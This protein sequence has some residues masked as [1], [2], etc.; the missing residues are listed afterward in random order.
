MSKLNVMLL[1]EISKAKGQFIAA[2]AVILA[3]IVMFSATYLS[4]RNL[5]NSLD[6]YYEQY[7]FLDYYAEARYIPE[8]IV[9]KVEHIKGVL[10]VSGRVSA[11][12]GA[13][14]GEERRI[15]LRILSLPDNGRPAVN[16]I[17]SI[18]GDYFN[19]RA[20]N[21]C[22]IN[23]KFAEY[24]NLHKGGTI[25]AIIDKRIYEFK[26]DGVVGSPE[27]IYAMKSSDSM[28]SAAENFGVI[29]VK[30]ST[31]F[32]LLG[33]N[34]CFN[35]LHVRFSAEADRKAIINQIEKMLVPYGFMSGVE[36]KDQLSNAMIETELSELQNMAVMFP[37]LFLSVAA[38]IIYNMLRRI[39]NNQRTQIGV[40]KSFGYTNQRIIFHYMGYAALIGLTGALA[41]S[42][43]GWY[44]GS[45]LTAMYTKVYNIPV[46]ENK[47]YW[48]VFLIGP[49]ISAIFCLTSG[50]NSA[51][52]VLGIEP[53][54]AM[55]PETPGV[56]RR[57]FLERVNFLWNKLS[58]GW[59]MSFRNIFR[60]R[61][62]AFLTLLGMIFTVMFLIISLYFFDA[63]N[64][65][66][67]QHFFEFQRQDYKVSF[68]APAS[69]ADAL[70]L[71]RIKGVRRSE[72]VLEIP[73]QLINGW[74]KEETLVVGLTR[75]NTFY[76][77]TDGDQNAIGV[78]AKGILIA[79]SLAEKLRV[80]KG[81]AISIKTYQGRTLQKDIIVAGTIKQYAGTNC[82][83]DL[84]ELGGLLE[85][86][87]FANG[88]L[89]G[90]EDGMERTVR[91][92]I[93][94]I[95]GV[96]TLESRLNSYRAFLQFME[97]IYTFIALML[98]F[99]SVMG[100]AIV[101]NTTVI[102][103][104][105]R[106]RELASLKVLGYTSGE[107]ERTV[108]RENLCLGLLSLLPGFIL[109]RSMCE[110]LSKMFGGELISLEVFIYPKT[111]LIATFSALTFI[112]L[113]QLANR[114]NITGLDMVEVLKNRE[115]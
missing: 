56:G 12:V 95:P 88:A 69:L 40:L 30:E 11:D 13:D 92:E 67:E 108:F 35:E 33:Y 24:H 28:F 68:S 77:L 93:F 109:G 57:I 105:E 16:H 61:Q 62:R 91:K 115:G 3:G 58:F 4:Y 44:T 103:I 65:L 85:E 96:E 15:T 98:I 37:I 55:R 63:V 106:R 90:I 86:G 14:I 20:E 23:R 87:G 49:V 112:I 42:L 72:P 110:I 1:R 99:G 32:K 26:I 48:E 19:A 36:R 52:K 54:Q 47:V 25:K 45:L 53:A 89:L 71:N 73:A 9:D 75:R 79:E 6:Y 17:L 82:Y 8:Y 51:R 111:Y 18:S 102:N 107:I 74:I 34:Y 43:L 59:K 83:M 70:E 22:L 50:F 60:S 114:K 76:R 66:L 78:P 7:R 27:F 64:Y 113:A 81:A 2:A 38:M 29:Y 100:F 97:F 5:K 104:T 101:F 10:A 94:Q 39:I 46:L 31:A 80:T 21:S 84:E 41:G